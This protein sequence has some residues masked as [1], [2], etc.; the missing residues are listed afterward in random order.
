MGRPPEE[1]EGTDDLQES[2]M[3]GNTAS[4]DTWPKKICRFGSICSDLSVRVRLYGGEEIAYTADFTDHACVG[5][6][7]PHRRRFLGA[8]L[9]FHS[10]KWTA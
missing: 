1:W 8:S 9:D 10:R 2:G 3:K 5:E 6:V 4:I 7:S